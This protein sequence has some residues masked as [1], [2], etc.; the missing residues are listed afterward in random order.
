M[1]CQALQPFPTTRGDILLDYLEL[2]HLPLL[3]GVLPVL[4]I[5]LGGYLFQKGLIKHTTKRRIPLSD[6]IVAS[7]LS[8]GCGG[9][10]AII[11][12]LLVL[13]KI[14]TITALIVASIFGSVLFFAV[15]VMTFACLHQKLDLRKVIRITTIPL[16]TILLSAI[17]LG[18]LCAGAS[19][20]K[21]EK[22][23]ANRA[24]IQAAGDKMDSLRLL[25][26]HNDNNMPSSLEE[27]VRLER[28]KPEDLTSPLLKGKPIGFL[29][30]QP[31][32]PPTIKLKHKQIILI[33]PPCE[34]LGDKH[35]L[36]LTTTG[37]L[38]TIPVDQ[39]DSYL[40][41]DVNKHWLPLKDKIINRAD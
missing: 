41:Y 28:A 36:I 17:L 21:H 11:P 1:S 7:L 39:L 13:M 27:L 18:G 4:W 15:G 34:T 22:I 32:I 24:L 3:I 29:Y 26:R 23:I 20:S 37:T 19:Y 2:W 38:R 31:L 33:A 12:I 30:A 35:V 9:A 25:L 14:K 5:V 8:G 40:D 16:A 6:G 10:V